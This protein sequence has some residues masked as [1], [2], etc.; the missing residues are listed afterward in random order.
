MSNNR[1]CD[2]SQERGSREEEGKPLPRGHLN[3]ALSPDECSF[4]PMD[5][6]EDLLLP[7]RKTCSMRAPHLGFKNSTKARDEIA[8]L[9]VRALPLDAGLSG[10][11]GLG[12]TVTRCVVGSPLYPRALRGAP[13]N[14]DLVLQ[15]FHFPLSP[16]P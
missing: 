6:S 8:P 3:W 14:Q 15:A 16:F 1:K 7:R 2:E 10:P 4:L 5:S 12:G 13:G 9:R 11:G